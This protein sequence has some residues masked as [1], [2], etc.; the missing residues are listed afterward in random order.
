VGNLPFNTAITDLRDHFSKGF[1][2]D[3]ES[4]FL[5]LKSNCA[6]INYST[7]SAC[8]EAA[9]RFLNSQ[10]MGASLV[11]RTRTSKSS[12]DIAGEHNNPE[13]EVRTRC[14][15]NLSGE[16]AFQ[17]E[18]P[19]TAMLGDEKTP[20]IKLKSKELERF[21]LL[22]SLTVEDLV[23]SVQYGIWTTQNHNEEL[24]N[25]AYYVSCQHTSSS[26]F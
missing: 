1:T 9:K 22:K 23:R 15:S 19:G 13:E 7:E 5:M 18:F 24:L 3:I 14:S 4:V 8:R 26:L 11:C 2:L 25:Q 21:F 16:T 17:K 20:E 10:F 6:F 12:T